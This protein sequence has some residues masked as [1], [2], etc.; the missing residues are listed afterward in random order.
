MKIFTLIILLIS[1]GFTSAQDTLKS[2]AFKDTR[3]RPKLPLVKP[4]HPSYPLINGYILVKE[5]QQG[6]PFAQHELG[7]RYLMG[8]G[9]SPDTSAAI[10]WIK[11]SAAQGVTSALFNFAI[12]LNSGTGVEWD[13][14]RAYKNFRL[15]AESGM[16]D[17]QYI[18]GLFFTD[19]LVVNKNMN[20]AYYWIKKAAD[21]GNEDALRTIKE[22]EERGVSYIPDSSMTK[23]TN[24]NLIY[25]KSAE[26]ET[27]SDEL[28]ELDFF[29][30]DDDTSE[31]S[32]QDVI[33][34]LEKQGKEKVQSKVG[35]SDEVVKSD[36]TDTTIT[37]IINFAAEAGSPEALLLKGKLIE[38]E[39]KINSESIKSAVY[40]LRAL[41]LGNSKGA[42]E[43]LRLSNNEEFVEELKRGLKEEN[44]DALYVLASLSA[45]GLAPRITDES[46]LGMFEKA[47]KR[48]HVPS[49]IALG[50]LYYQGDLVEK[51]E[52]KSLRLL[53][54]AAMMGSREAEIRLAAEIIKQNRTDADAAAAVRLLTNASDAGSVLASL[55]LAY[56]YENGVVVKQHK[57]KASRLYRKAAARGNETGF[58]ALKRMYDE[59]RP[60]EEEFVIFEE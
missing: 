22:L 59:L 60:S 24:E 48:D 39:E 2:Q 10:N 21:Q 15:S 45:L 47:V 17:G 33:E 49:I 41:R 53:K 35:L 29:Q 11:K 6:D 9:F 32:G 38:P 23:E 56:C 44:P 57:G 1:F 5:A 18:F 37:G 20:R 46:A 19:N 26:S 50:L 27:L 25:Y 7:L 51:D 14:F 31:L 55:T 36:V 8:K 4:K 52:E 12:L 30:F 13:P 3:I 42:G 43:L 16:S 58:N 34:T 54:H 40:Y 28:V